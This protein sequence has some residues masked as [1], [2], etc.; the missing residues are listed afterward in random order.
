MP[1]SC[2]MQWRIAVKIG[3][4]GGEFMHEQKILIKDKYK[5]D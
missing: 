4:A 3:K 2:S 5:G 1:E